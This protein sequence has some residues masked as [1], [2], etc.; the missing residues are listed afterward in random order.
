MSIDNA[1]PEEWDRLRNSKAS[2]AE[3]WNRIYDDDN[4]PNHHPRFS[5]EAMDISSEELLDRF[6]DKFI[7]RLQVFEAEVDEDEVELEQDEY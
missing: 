2:I 6:E 1:T 7:N 3:A 4:E 5:E